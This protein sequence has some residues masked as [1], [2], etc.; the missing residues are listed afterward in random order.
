MNTGEIEKLKT[1]ATSEII[2]YI[3]DSVGNKTI[4]KKPTGSIRVMSFD[5][6]VGLTETTSP[7]DTFVQ[8]IEGSAEFIIDGTSVSLETGQCIIIPAHRPNLIKANGR[9][10]MILTVIKSGYE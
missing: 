8:I 3:P 2:D 9:F 5:N 6:G 7:F 4:I 1:Y 10:K